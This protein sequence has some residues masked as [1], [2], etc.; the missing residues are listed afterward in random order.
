M[1]VNIFGASKIIT[2]G[3]GGGK[4]GERGIGFNLDAYN[5]F[6]INSKRLVNIAEPYNGNDAATRV[7]VD[8]IRDE[9]NESISTNMDTFT[10]ES[11]NLT[12]RVNDVEDKIEDITSDI[13]EVR[14]DVS[15]VRSFVLRKALN[16]IS[17]IN[18]KLTELEEKLNTEDG[19]DDGEVDR[20]RR[21]VPHA[22]VANLSQKILEQDKKIRNLFTFLN[23]DVSTLNSRLDE[24]ST[25]VEENRL[26]VDQNM[27][28]IADIRHNGVTMEL[29]DGW[30]F[31]THDVLMRE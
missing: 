28:D 8:K 20:I 17:T 26:G 22:V 23:R 4:K 16:P 1:S 2:R 7:Y 14:E 31:N 12:I 9:L 30:V 3:D 6:D 21:N 29:E 24:L 15:S 18:K 25:Q 13:S 27:L 19:D 11:N 5:N 10:V